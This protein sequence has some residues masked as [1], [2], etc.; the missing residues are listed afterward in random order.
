LGSGSKPGTGS[1][2]SL[3]FYH[4]LTK[5]NESISIEFNETFVKILQNLAN[6][7]KLDEIVKIVTKDLTKLCIF[8]FHK[9]F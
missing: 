6:V 1:F 2:A 8:E 4:N 7:S 3:D 5:L 9:L